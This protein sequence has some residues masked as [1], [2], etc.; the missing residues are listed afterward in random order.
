MA[1]PYKPR[2]KAPALELIEK[3]QRIIDTYNLHSV[4]RESACPNIAECFERE[5]A[6][7]LIMGDRCT[8]SCRFCNVSTDKP[9]SLDP[10][11]PR[12]LAEAIRDLGLKYVVVTSVDRDDLKDLGAGHFVACVEAIHSLTPTVNI[13][14]LTPDFK[15]KEVL[16]AHIV[17]AHPHKLAHNMETVRRLSKTL[18]P[19]S[20]YD[21]SLRTL[22]FYAASGIRTKTSLMLGLGETEAEILEAM[23]EALDAG[24]CDITLG[25]YLQPSPR[26][27]KV[28]R[29]YSP[30]VF[31][32]LGEIA[33]GM[34]FEGVASG[35]L[36]RSS[37]YADRL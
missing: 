37:Y 18:R 14:L 28:V 7:F 26:H 33:R 29:Y 25:Q 20:D 19:Q 9:L 27:A 2:V 34:G 16:L 6:T 36:V 10:A 24:V 13:E 21:R 30:E 17:A 32:K 23:R 5:S 1:S 35:V 8:R 22:S 3:T 12:R 31:D 15:A 11:E 4:C